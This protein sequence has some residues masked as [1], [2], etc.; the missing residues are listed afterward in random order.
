MSCEDCT[1]GN[2]L[3]GE[4][5]GAIDTVSKAYLAA[6]PEPSSRAIILLTDVFGLPLQNC[7]ILADRLSKELAC[8]VWVPDMFDGARH[9]SVSSYFIWLM[10]M[11]TKGSP[12]L[13]VGQLN[14]PDVPGVKT[15]FRDYLYMFILLIRRLPHFIRSRP[16]KCDE[17]ID[18]VDFL[19]F[20]SW[21][22]FL[23]HLPDSLLNIWRK[24]R[25]TR[26]SGLLGAFLP[27]ITHPR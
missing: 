10:L 16:S 12:I 25:S 4:P 1:K 22:C 8:D 11:V 9:L 24:K 2:V 19:F 5:T 6:A 21:L 27:F 20:L 14:H 23:S 18:K 3:P 26:R 7:K 13:K 15:T 17:R